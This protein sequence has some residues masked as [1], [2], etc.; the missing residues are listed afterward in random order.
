MEA[1]RGSPA[2]A[3]P[4]EQAH[5]SRA[6]CGCM[7]LDCCWPPIGPPTEERETRSPGSS[8]TRAN[9]AGHSCR[10]RCRDAAEIAHDTSPTLHEGA[11]GEWVCRVDP[12]LTIGDGPWTTFAGGQVRQHRLAQAVDATAPCVTPA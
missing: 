11:I 5:R 6:R 4:I 2:R 3:S 12:T 7:Q 10:L 8:P 9:V 1:T